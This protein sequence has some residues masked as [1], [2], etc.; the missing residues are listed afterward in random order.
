M[1]AGL[2]DYASPDDTVVRLCLLPRGNFSD[3]AGLLGHLCE[4]K[5]YRICIDLC[6]VSN[7][8]TVEF[9][10]LTNFSKI[11]KQHGGFLKLE[12]VS[13]ALTKLVHDFG[14]NH[15]LMV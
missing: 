3:L 4:R 1:N 10:V 14:C 7:W 5:R 13:T 15:L 11:L 8:G 12:N 9:R 6:A 2:Q